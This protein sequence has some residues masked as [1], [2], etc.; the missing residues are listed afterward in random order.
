MNK[1]IGGPEFYK[2]IRK[3]IDKNNYPEV[4]TPIFRELRENIDIQ[5]FLSK[6]TDQHQNYGND[7]LLDSIASIYFEEKRAFKP[8][9]N[10]QIHNEILNT[11][12][13]RLC[14]NLHSNFSPL[15]KL[16]LHKNETIFLLSDFPETA[17]KVAYFSN[18]TTGNIITFR[19]D[20][21]SLLKAKD[22]LFNSKIV[23]ATIDFQTKIPGIF[24]RLSDSMLKLAYIIKPITFFGAQYVKDDGSL[25]YETINIDF[26]KSIEE[27]KS[28]ILNLIFKNRI[29]SEFS[30]S[31]F[32][33]IEQIKML[34]IA[35]QLINKQF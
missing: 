6:N 27:S 34:K 2:Y 7:L 5:I 4:I 16:V 13:P 18:I 29:R 20:K 21:S 1:I 10:Y 35:S 9:I 22:F 15:T 23:S 8:I 30:W 25:F 33:H 24:N 19:R 3:V 26:S 12:V 17:K 28:L 11:S 32:N 14:L 31:T